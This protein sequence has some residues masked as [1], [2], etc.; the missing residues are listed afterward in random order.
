MLNLIH[1]DILKLLSLWFNKWILVNYSWV[2]MYEETDLSLSGLYF[3]FVHCPHWLKD[4]QTEKKYIYKDEI[5][6]RQRGGNI[7][8]FSV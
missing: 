4:R 3:V 7:C 6:V 8:Y 1:V 5:N 2:G